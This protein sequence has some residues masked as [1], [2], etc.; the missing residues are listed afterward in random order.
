MDDDDFSPHR[1]PTRPPA[2]T[3]APRPRRPPARQPLDPAQQRP[4]R[5][6][7]PG[8]HD[9]RTAAQRPGPAPARPIPDPDDAAKTMGPSGTAGQPW[10]LRAARQ[11]L[12]DQG[13]WEE[14]TPWLARLRRVLDWARRVLT[15]DTMLAVV[16]MVLFGVLLITACTVGPH[17]G[18]AVCALTHGRSCAAASATPPDGSIGTSQTVVAAASAT[19]G[20]TVTPTAAATATASPVLTATADPNTGGSGPP[21][22]TAPPHQV[23]LQGNVVVTADGLFSCPNGSVCVVI[24]WQGGPSW[25]TCGSF[26]FTFAGQGPQ[27]VTCRLPVPTPSTIT[28]GSFQGACWGCGASR[29][30]DL[31]WTNPQPFQ[32]V[33]SG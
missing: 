21:T 5:T 3:P 29:K 15:E 32:P 1:R 9:T 2:P 33:F 31:T 6:A 18:A 10:P 13:L 20:V 16:G 19:L 4:V 25:A 28:A 17:I 14:V 22:P 27:T 12:V 24:S 7:S 30:T 11:Y 23:A 8:R 26:A